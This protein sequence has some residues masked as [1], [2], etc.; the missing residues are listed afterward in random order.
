AKEKEEDEAFAEFFTKLILDASK[1]F[2]D[3]Q[4]EELKAHF[5]PL[6]D[7]TLK[8][9]FDKLIAS[10][11]GPFGEIA[12]AKGLNADLF[13]EALANFNALYPEHAF[14]IPGNVQ[15][16]GKYAVGLE[17]FIDHVK[18]QANPEIGK[19]MDKGFVMQVFI[20]LALYGGHQIG[21]S[22]LRADGV[23]E[24]EY[25]LVVKRCLE[26]AQ[27]MFTHAIPSD[28][29]NLAKFL[30]VQRKPSQQFEPNMLKRSVELLFT[31]GKAEFPRADKVKGLEILVQARRDAELLDIQKKNEEAAQKRGRG[32]MKKKQ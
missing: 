7:H 8:R 17:K 20:D 13:K 6:R 3:E 5:T 31:R 12:F 11:E 10:F 4:R 26:R 29:Q 21:A 24:K 2:D 25:E 22:L 30:S 19:Q 16:W 27:Q 9:Y 23:L 32:A 18:K 1:A 28:M 14:A 15:M